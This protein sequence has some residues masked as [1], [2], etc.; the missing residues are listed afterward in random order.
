M[1]L[2]KLLLDRFGWPG[3]IAFAVPN[4]LGCA[5][6]GYVVK[7]R[8]RS[9][10]MVLKHGIAMA[11][12]SIVTIAYHV[13][14]LCL[15]LN[16][17]TDIDRS[18]SNGPSLMA[19]IAMLWLAILAVASAWMGDR[20]WLR[21]SIAIYAASLVLCSVV[22]WR[23]DVA[24]EWRGV[25]PPAQLAWLAIPMIIGF[26]TCPY[27]DLTFH[28]AIEQSPSRHA[29]AIFGVAFL[30]LILFTCFIWPSNA[31]N[32]GPL[33]LAHILA[34]SV[35]TCGAHMREL[36]QRG[37]WARWIGRPAGWAAL[38]LLACAALFLFQSADTIEA[39][40]A[41]YLR[42]LGF[43]GL[44]FPAYVLLFIGPARPLAP[45]LRTLVIFT[46]VVFALAPLYELA[47]IRGVS[48]VMI[49][50][51][52]AASAWLVARRVPSAMT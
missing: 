28:R 35:F 10:S 46:L 42:W 36:R 49:V 30:V 31:R 50:P 21:A 6:F 14:F 3:F 16:W 48:W 26:L 52:L 22:T 18:I 7:N 39:G 27:L 15:L 43:Y 45:S 20:G 32:L 44:V 33:A 51:A 29:F 12:F 23:S 2:P 17:L 1:Y 4:V 41:A 37:L 38:I 8:Q 19:G 34:Q 40:N 13:L 11:A 25:E 9:E 5:A 47:F 24:Y